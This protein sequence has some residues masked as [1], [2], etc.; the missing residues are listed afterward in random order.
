MA[1]DAYLFFEGGDPKIEGESQDKVYGPKKAME[2]YSFS[3]GIANA[4]TLGSGTSGAG[5][6]KAQLSSFSFQKKTDAASAKLYLACAKG[7]HYPK[8]T[9]VLRKAG[10]NPLEFITYVFE[11]VFV[12]NVQW[13]GSTGGDDSPQESVSLVFGKAT[14][15]YTKQKSDGTA[16]GGAISSSWNQQKNTA[17]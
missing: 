3:W 2:I 11:T 5:G 7:V 9:V 14:I 10:G 8:V 16:D 17:D 13:G 1:F 12:E 15:N 6:G 4:T